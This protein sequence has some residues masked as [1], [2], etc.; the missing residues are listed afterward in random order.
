MS[1]D[2][3]SDWL[4]QSSR[5]RSRIKRWSKDLDEEIDFTVKHQEYFRRQ[6]E[7]K[8]REINNW[9]E[10]D[11]FRGIIEAAEEA[12]RIQNTLGRSTKVDRLFQ[13]VA[14]FF[15]YFLNS[16]DGLLLLNVLGCLNQRVRILRKQIVDSDYHGHLAADFVINKYGLSA[17]SPITTYRN[18][19]GGVLPPLP[20]PEY[21][22]V[23]EGV[24]VNCLAKS[25]NTWYPN[26]NP[27]YFLEFLID[28]VDK[29]ATGSPRDLKGIPLT[30]EYNA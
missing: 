2:P 21:T 12:E 19:D 7:L 3:I 29:I 5:I 1:N 30:T 18:Q 6:L 4:G 13:E 28:E 24:F 23:D 9:L 11:D 10:S 26:Q 17:S 22:E 8:K 25:W 15:E 14:K 27:L 16:P 20:A